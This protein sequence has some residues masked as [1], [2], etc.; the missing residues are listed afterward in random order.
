MPRA[1][2]VFAAVVALGADWPSWRGPTG[3][4]RAADAGYPLQWSATENVKW[5]TP[6]AGG[7]HSSP[8]VAG[9]KVFVTGCVEAKRER[10]LYCLDKA[11]GAILWERAVLTSP[12][13]GKHKLNSFASSTPACDGER[14]FVTFFDEPKARVYCYSVSGEKLW[15]KSPGEFHSKHGFC[16]S[17]TLYKDLVIVNCDQDAVAYVVAF[18]RRSGEEKWRID[19]PNR[20]RSY[21]PPIVFEA[22]GRKQM[23]MTGSKCVCGYDPDTGKRLW[24]VDGPTEQFVASMVMARGVF[25]LTAGFPEYWVMA[26]RPDGNGNVTKTHV[27]WSKKNEGGYVPSP[28]A[29]GDHFFTAADNGIATCWDAKTGELKWKERLGRHYS[30]SAVAAEGRI[31]FIDDDGV[32]T[33][34]KAS[35]QFQVLA[36]NPIGEKCFTSP[37]FSDG[38]IFVRG[39]KHLICIGK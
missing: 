37:A 21:C 33:V 22:A 4:G 32:T 3:D 2:L 34:V 35:D 14:V 19:R 24:I 12:L 25:F 9:G 15:E 16:S 13:E 30:G 20:T 23:V 10:V 26:I 8:V 17:P 18:D 5:K 31:F 36:K 28:V 6:L 7:G 29:H 11:T 1:I 27:A 39:E 38:K